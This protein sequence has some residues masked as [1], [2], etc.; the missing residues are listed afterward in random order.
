MKLAMDGKA[1]KASE[2]SVAA[3]EKDESGLGRGLH[4]KGTVPSGRVSE[5]GC[6]RSG[7]RVWGRK[8]RP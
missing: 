8:E 5:G 3:A 4:H 1:S 6:P 2:E 7:R